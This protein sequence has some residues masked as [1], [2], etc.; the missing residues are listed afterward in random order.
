MR[1]VSA[2]VATLSA[3]TLLFGAQDAKAAGFQNMSQSATANGMGSIGAANPDEP[4]SSFYNPA[5]MSFREGFN[6]YVGDTILV[7]T[8]T[9][10]DG[11]ADEASTTSA[12][13]P[14]PNLHISSPIAAGVAVGFGLTLPYGLGITWDDDWEGR[15]NIITQQLQTFNFNPNVSYKIPGLDLSLAVGAQVFYSSV[16]LKR[17]IIL[18]DDTEILAH[19]GG[20]GTG[21][22]ATAAVMYKP[23]RDL[24]FGLNY[25]SGAKV[26]YTGKGDFSGQEGTPFESSFVDQDIS[27]EIN[28]PHAVTLGVGYKLDKL[29][30]GVDTNYTT[31]SSYEK[32]ELQFSRP[33]TAG[34]NTCDPNSDKTDPPTSVIQGD[35]ND[36]FAFRLG[37]Q[38]DVSE[39]LKVR[40]GAVYDMT[41]IPD[42]TVSAS[43]PDNNRA[44]FSLGVGYTVADLIRLD[45]SYQFVSAAQRTISNGIAPT[46]DY[47]TTAHVIGLN[48]GYGF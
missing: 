35:W 9:Y 43:L 37:L 11:A 20:D 23:T 26:S 21:F 47:K 32:V 45:G 8:T 29:F 5:N 40:A 39:A 7:P 12:I 17:K 22:G 6:V 1:R 27:T 30:I 38:Y 13:F 36:A 28:L 3:A 34:S 44:A 41:P 15:S 14:P 4:N 31:W 46:G 18:R 16:E 24:T 25:R 42:E 2:I 48:V 19:L 10:N 33:C